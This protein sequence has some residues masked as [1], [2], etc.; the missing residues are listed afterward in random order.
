MTWTG[1]I[2]GDGP[3]HARWHQLVRADEPAGRHI[4]LLGFAS[5]EGVRRNE[6]RV[7]AAKGPV[8]LRRALSSMA[9]HGDLGDGTVAIHDVGDVV[10]DGED[11]EGGQDILGERVASALDREGNALTVVLGGGHETAWGSY[12]GLAAATYPGQRFGVLNLDAHFDLRDA[13]RPSSGT[14]FL[15]MARAREAAGLPF[16]Y[17]VVGISEHSNTRAL[18]ERAD[19][20][21]VDYLLDVDCSAERVTDFVAN[22]AAGLDVLYL[23]VDLDVLPA[24][25][26]PG[27]SAP[28]ALG[29]DPCLVVAAVRAAAGTGKLRLMDVVELN[30]RLDVDDRT[31]RIGARLVADAVA[32]VARRSP[33]G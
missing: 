31:A 11:L 19:S 16:C 4:A 18:F 7:G 21:G 12:L 14:P 26:A 15:Q 2:D 28:A 10:V 9:L 3:E 13:D 32:A 24:S 22:F 5:D 30:P 33:V 27:V 23:T 29:L 6:G 20:L 1:R 17:G 25:V 8:A